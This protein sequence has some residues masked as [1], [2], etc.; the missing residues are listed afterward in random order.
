MHLNPHSFTEVS[1]GM[2]NKVLKSDSGTSH[3]QLHLSLSCSEMARCVFSA[4]GTLQSAL[5]EQN[6]YMEN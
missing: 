1:W 6:A 3:S 2:S 4:D 5:S